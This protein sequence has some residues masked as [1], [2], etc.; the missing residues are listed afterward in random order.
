M[1]EGLLNYPPRPNSNGYPPNAGKIHPPS[2]TSEANSAQ[3]LANLTE[4]LRR[5]MSQMQQSPGNSPGNFF[6]LQQNFQRNNSEKRS[7]SNES[8]KT[9]VENV[10][11]YNPLGFMGIPGLHI[12][13]QGVKEE[14]HNTN[15]PN[16]PKDMFLKQFNNSHFK[17]HQQKLA[18]RTGA[19]YPEYPGGINF[20]ALANGM[21]HKSGLS[22]V[23]PRF[24]DFFQNHPV[25]DLLNSTADLE[26]REPPL[27]TSLNK[28]KME[29]TVAD[30]RED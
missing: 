24:E 14:R 10:G 21:L 15:T 9:P 27:P 7:N 8:P 4:N 25:V 26:N 3:S 23:S 12:I 16:T 18:A 13:P 17:Q 30:N 2:P 19:G 1:H 11:E 28:I 5:Q 20:E 6:G 22:S 29:P